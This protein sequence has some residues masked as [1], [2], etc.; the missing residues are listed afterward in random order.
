MPISG[1]T[2]IPLTMTTVRNKSIKRMPPQFAGKGTLTPLLVF[3][4]KSSWLKHPS[5]N[6]FDDDPQ[7][8]ARPRCQ[9]NPWSL[10][11]VPQY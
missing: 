4:S 11:S 6:E 8:L 5:D 2:A 1:L 7:C 10:I 9:N 3:S